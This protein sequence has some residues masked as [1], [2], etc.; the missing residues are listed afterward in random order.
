MLVVMDAKR[1]ASPLVG[2]FCG[3]LIAYIAQIRS[4]FLRTSGSS[5]VFEGFLA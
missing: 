1:F 3:G 2:I 4:L 5:G